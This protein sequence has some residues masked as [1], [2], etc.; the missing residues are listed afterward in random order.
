MR[1][2]TGEE[3]EFDFPVTALIGTNG[4]GK[5]T[6]LGA[7]AIAYKAIRP[8]L[9]FP[10]SSLGDQ[11]MANWS[12]GYELIEKSKNPTQTIQRRARFLNAKWARDDLIDRKVLY[13]GINRTVPAGERKK[14]SKN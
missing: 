8:A 3:V 7:A 10:K 13:F 4:G 12:I 14:S 9:F 2:F 11:S 5:S 1:A 6:V